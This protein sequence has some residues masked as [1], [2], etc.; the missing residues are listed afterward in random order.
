MR[1]WQILIIVSVVG[2]FLDN[3]VSNIAKAIASKNEH[4]DKNGER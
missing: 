1:W 2:L 4:K 3:M